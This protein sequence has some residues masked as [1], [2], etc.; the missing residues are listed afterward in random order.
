MS[1]ISFRNVSISKELWRVKSDF[2]IL[3]SLFA[4]D[5]S[6]KGDPKVSIV[7]RRE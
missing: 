4:I 3:L 7:V 2:L 5:P 6:A 1:R